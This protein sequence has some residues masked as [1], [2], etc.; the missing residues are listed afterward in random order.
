M[1]TTFL[2]FQI[3]VKDTPGGKVIEAQADDG[4][5]GPDSQ[6]FQS[7][8]AVFSEA[9]YINE[10][11][12]ET[13]RLWNGNKSQ[14]SPIEKGRKIG[15]RFFQ[16]LFPGEIEG[17]FR[18]K[19]NLVGPFTKYKFL[20]IRLILTEDLSELPWELLCDTEL[21]FLSTVP[22]ISIVRSFETSSPFTTL[23]VEK[24][25]SIAGVVA[26]PEGWL[27][28]G[29]DVEEYKAIFHKFT[30]QVST[31]SEVV[32]D[33]QVLEGVNTVNKI[34]R[35]LRRPTHIVDIICHGA[36]FNSDNEGILILESPEGKEY[37][38]GA[39]ALWKRLV[40]QDCD[41]VRL[42]F[43][44]ACVS[45]RQIGERLFS[46]IGA[47]IA[48]TKIPAV[49]SMR[50]MMSVKA[51]TNLS[52]CF[53]EYL[54]EDGSI[55]V[56]MRRA[57][58]DLDEGEF[59][60]TLSF[61]VPVLYLRAKDST[62]FKKN[63]QATQ[64]SLHK[65]TD[66]IPLQSEEV[67]PETREEKGGSLD[68]YHEEMSVFR[69]NTLQVE[70]SKRAGRRSEKARF[71]RSRMNDSK[72]RGDPVSLISA[73]RKDII[74]LFED[75]LHDETVSNHSKA[76]CYLELSQMYFEEDNFD[77][78]LRCCNESARIYP[79]Y[80]AIYEMRISVN[81][82]REHQQKYEDQAIKSIKQDL[83]K[84]LDLGEKV[85]KNDLERYKISRRRS[86]GR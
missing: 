32:A 64:D 59:R 78:A 16:S 36:T 25:L 46:S 65:I 60:E 45:A 4:A 22:Q 53:Y 58:L 54:A 82:Q 48:R 30:S 21:G 57:R 76:D 26:E 85:D 19:Y 75:V 49:V 23:L 69:K 52:E 35:K 43:L 20:R 73:M 81:K 6:T 33:Y 15:L 11:V 83:R 63:S 28:E 9:I 5:K 40:D 18:Q 39:E 77:Q 86:P 56:A 70:V 80:S 31:T 67:A 84:L 2:N 7:F 51:A 37:R 34:R 3:T 68:G 14:L 17:Y 1:T 66:E 74:K 29:F 50:F 55:D 79:D 27:F 62:I 71:L 61:A 10:W 72:T 41:Y 12:E 8:P 47:S 42:V 38:I 24:S 13:Y 44:K